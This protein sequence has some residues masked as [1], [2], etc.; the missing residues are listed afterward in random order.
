MEIVVNDTNVFIDL[1][2]IALIDDFFRLPISVHTVDF[3]LNEIKNEEQRHIINRFIE[4]G[5]LTV[6]TFKP[7][8]V[9]QIIE[10]RDSAG[11][12]VSFED[13]AVWHYAKKNNYTLLTG[14]GQL[15]KKAIASN[16]MVKGIIY[17]F[18]ELVAYEIIT[19]LLAVAKLQELMSKNPRLPKSI[20]QERINKWSKLY[21][22]STY[23]TPE[24]FIVRVSLNGNFSQPM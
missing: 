24:I 23:N 4:N 22:I 16:V 3:V 11:G 14:D 20:I 5:K 13:C 6:G 10:L 12:N 9:I 8:E 7:T 2:S 21:G 19:P 15:R 18:D 17:V 1:C